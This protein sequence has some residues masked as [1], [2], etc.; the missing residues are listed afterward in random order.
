MN[1]L[2]KNEIVRMLCE[3]KFL[4]TTLPSSS[5]L[6]FAIEIILNRRNRSKISQRYIKTQ[7]VDDAFCRMYDAM[8]QQ[9]RKISFF[10]DYHFFFA[11]FK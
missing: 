3:F 11:V 10:F 9:E 6:F 5:V 8:Q 4:E 2:K 7:R 1:A